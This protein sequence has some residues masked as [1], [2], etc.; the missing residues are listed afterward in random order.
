MYLHFLSGLLKKKKKNY[1]DVECNLWSGVK[2]KHFYFVLLL[3]WIYHPAWIKLPL[4]A[5]SFSTSLS[6][7]WFLGLGVEQVPPVFVTTYRK[8]IGVNPKTENAVCCRLARR[9]CETSELPRKR[10]DAFALK[11]LF[12]K[13]SLNIFITQQLPARDLKV[14]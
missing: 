8:M 2:R 6:L 5:T 10:L 9:M 4:A 3:M 11:K 13:L 1:K 7:L 12:K 14:L